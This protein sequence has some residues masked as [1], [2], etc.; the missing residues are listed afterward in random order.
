MYYT[1]RLLK[2]QIASEQLQ[3][4]YPNKNAIM[5][6]SEILFVFQPFATRSINCLFPLL[7]MLTFLFQLSDGQ[8]LRLYQKSERT[9]ILRDLIP[10]LFLQ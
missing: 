8:I 2:K 3:N 6:A 7:G 5:Y 4:Q 10:F 1:L 9:F